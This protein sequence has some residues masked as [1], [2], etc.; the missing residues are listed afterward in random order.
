MMAEHFAEQG[1][2]I[3]IHYNSSSDDAETLL[4][5]LNNSEKHTTIQANLSKLK[6]AEELLP[7]LIKDWGA[8]DV[9]INNASTYFRRGMSK[10][11]NDELVDDFTVNFFSPLVLMR[12][13]KKLCGK[14]RII[15]FVD[16][17]VDFT[18]PEA[19]P[20]ALAKKSLR[21]ATLA[22]AEEWSPDIQVNAIAPGPVLFPD[23][24]YKQAQKSDSLKRILEKVEELL[25]KDY[26]A[27]ITI[28]E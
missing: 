5:S 7:K 3:A 1:H 11:T 18:D 24:D 13:F 8:P 4:H 17:R 10:F 20:Y 12:E 15:N 23:E 21:D 22:C 25:N 28:I 6:D 16:R 2:H 14:G 9:I 19:G 26:T 27:S